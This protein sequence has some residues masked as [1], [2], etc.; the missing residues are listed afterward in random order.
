MTDDQV[1]REMDIDF[2]RSASG[3]VYPEFSYDK[4]MSVEVR[5]DDS[6]P[7]YGCMDFGIGAATAAYLFQVAPSFPR[8][9]VLSDYEQENAP[10]EVNARNVWSMAQKIGFK[11]SRSEVRWYGDPAGNAREIATGSSVIREYRHAGFLNFITPRIKKLDGI[12]LVRRFLHRGDILFS[13]DCGMTALR[14][15]D[16][17]Y[18]TD[19]SGAV[20]GD[21]PVKNKATH[22]MDALRYGITGLFPTDEGMVVSMKVEDDG[23]IPQ[24]AEWDRD[25]PPANVN[26]WT[27][28][29]VGARKQY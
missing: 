29:I 20:K 15:A 5:Y 16:Y 28:S 19:D 17:R 27:K 21:E 3:L 2:S 10:A 26:A 9:R 4:H 24:P 22:L 11:G 23:V 12:R 6:L 8:V 7:L 14:I 25:L 13:V 1:A 18:P